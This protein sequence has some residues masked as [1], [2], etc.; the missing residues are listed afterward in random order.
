M[1]STVQGN[2]MFHI[3]FHVMDIMDVMDIIMDIMDVMASRRAGLEYQWRSKSQSCGHEL[4]ALPSQP[5]PVSTCVNTS[6]YYGTEIPS[7]L[8]MM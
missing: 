2:F 7:Q 8:C 6:T 5:Q 1:L 3:M 4:P